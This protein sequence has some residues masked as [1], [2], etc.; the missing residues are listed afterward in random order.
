[1]KPEQH[2]FDEQA[3]E[4]Y[5]ALGRQ[6]RLP[7]Q[8]ISA[9]E[10]RIR[11][12]A[13]EQKEQEGIYVSG[14][15]YR[16]I[17]AHRFALR[18]APLVACA[19]L[20]VS[21]GLIYRAGLLKHSEFETAESDFEVAV[22]TGTFAETG[23]TTVAASDA[24]TQ[25]VTVISGT[26]ESKPDESNM[27]VTG[28]PAV[29]SSVPEQSAVTD[30]QLP[31]ADAQDGT[32]KQTKATTAPPPVTTEARVTTEVPVTTAVEDDPPVMTEEMTAP[33]V[34]IVLP[35]TPEDAVY[36]L[37]NV[38]AH[39]GEDVTV[40]VSFRQE[41]AAAGFSLYLELGTLS[42]AAL[43]QIVSY[44]YPIAGMTSPRIS[45][46]CSGDPES[47]SFIVTWMNGKDVLIPAGTD[48]VL[49]TLHIPEDTPSGTVYQL[50]N[51]E[52]QE[53]DILKVVSVEYPDRVP[54]SYYIGN[55]FVE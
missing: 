28:D 32:G 49:V 36:A 52:K 4:I 29:Q 34:Q 35:E 16:N 42:D 41:T 45:P 50:Y 8:R 40:S 43:P 30:P 27:P 46:I 47:G 1:M 31:A 6:L 3:P 9:M 38:L 17:S 15:R 10:Q 55:I 54:G 2:K 53:I 18:A 5:R 37:D 44:S 21:G 12:K 13:A 33:P 39:P 48:I 25:T 14:G 11:S 19:V 20:M 22:Q 23:L 7:E 51:P 26:S 24:V